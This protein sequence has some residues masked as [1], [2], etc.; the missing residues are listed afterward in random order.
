M[1]SEYGGLPW[2]ITVMGCD[3]AT[4]LGV[5]LHTGICIWCEKWGVET[6]ELVSCILLKWVTK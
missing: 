2:V 4:G 5:W 6:G 1:P 3:N